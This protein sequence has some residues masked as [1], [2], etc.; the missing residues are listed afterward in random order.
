[1]SWQVALRLGRVSNLPTVWTNTLAGIVLASG[2]LVDA[3]APLLLVALS[4]FYVGGMYLND[5][6]DAELDAKE[7]P[8]RPIPSGQISARTVFIAGFAMLGLGLLL[9]M[10]AGLDQESAFSAVVACLNNLGP[11]L[12]DVAENYAGLDAAVKW[13]LIFAMLLGRLEI[14]TLLVLFSPA[15]WRR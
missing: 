1:M 15:F 11:G 3:R 7:R 6:F 9:L 13:G 4:L 5:A 8:E 14:F 12:G 2:T 10:A